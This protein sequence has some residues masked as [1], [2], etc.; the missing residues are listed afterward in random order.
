MQSFEIPDHGTIEGMSDTAAFAPPGSELYEKHIK[1]WSKAA[2]K[3]ASFILLPGCAEDVS[4]SILFCN[5]HGLDFAVCGGGHATS[6]S[7]SSNG[8]VSID[9]SRMNR[10]TVDA[11]GK[12]VTAQG[13]ALWRD[14]DAEAEKYGLAAVGGTVNH[15]GVGGL[16]LGGGYGYLTPA[17]GLVIDNILAVEYVL[18]DGQIITASEKENADLFWAARGAGTCFGVATSFT[19]RAHE[20]KDPVWAALLRFENDQLPAVIDFGNRF[21]E[22]GDERTLLLVAFAKVP[23]FGDIPSIVAVCFYKGQ[24]AMG[25]SFYDD[26][27]HL[28]P[29]V[30]KMGAI[31][32]SAMNAYQNDIVHHGLRRSMK[33]SAFMV[34]LSL[35]RIKAIQEEFIEFV[36]DQKDADMSAALI[37]YYPF[38]NLIRIPQTATAFANRG[39]YSNLVF[40]ITWTKEELD[41][42]CR[43]KARRWTSMVQEE[44]QK[45]KSA[46]VSAGEVDSVTKDGIGEYM[47]Y[48]G[49]GSDGDKMFGVNY[50]RLREL[51]L[52][53]DP[54]NLFNRVQ[55]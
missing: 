48:D 2:E 47:N 20:Q 52:R 7:S 26:L 35:G 4:K 44:F 36:S 37:E 30:L 23:D 12:T 9:L 6:G 22:I 42:I 41:D 25:K 8:G 19:Y 17:H 31:P 50:P 15:T 10:V 16:S 27:F 46:M 55:S 33:G 53:Y 38:K 28:N 11:E 32:Y 18:S 21:L 24:E 5:K 40:I 14:V 34:P 51:K 39:A 49:F 1:R 54:K 29:T 13:G 43:G 3:P 45:V